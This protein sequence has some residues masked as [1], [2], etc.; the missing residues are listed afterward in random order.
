MRRRV[1][2]LN[3][4]QS[5][6]FSPFQFS[7][8]MLGSFSGICSRSEICFFDE[9]APAFVAIGG[10]LGILKGLQFQLCAL[11]APDHSDHTS[12]AV[13]ANVMPDDGVR[14]GEVVACQKGSVPN[15]LRNDQAAICRARKFTADVA[16]DL[17]SQNQTLIRD[18]ASDVLRSLSSDGR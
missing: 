1:R 9:V 15:S 17:C 4:P 7:L 16:D 8:A 10:L 11:L 3:L 12:R 5:F 14:V 2:S 6:R 18:E 13:G